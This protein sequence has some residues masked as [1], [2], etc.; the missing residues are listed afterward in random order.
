M[1]GHI[2]FSILELRCILE[3]KVCVVDVDFQRAVVI[4]FHYQYSLSCFLFEICKR[5]IR[6]QKRNFGRAK[7]SKRAILY[8]ILN[9]V[10]NFVVSYVFF[11]IDCGVRLQRSQPFSR[12]CFAFWERMVV[13][14]T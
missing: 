14:W 9:F 3:A 4:P 12:R 10:I 6:R 8:E 2:A 1:N 11:L 7:C 5:K 13:L